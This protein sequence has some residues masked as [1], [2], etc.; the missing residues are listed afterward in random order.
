MKKALPLTLILIGAALLITAVVFW[1]DSSTSVEPE[2]FGKSLRD[3]ITLIAGLGVSIKGWLDL[4]KKEKPS[5]SQVNED[6]GVIVSGRVESVGEDIV[7]RDKIVQNIHL[8]SEKVAAIFTNKTSSDDHQENPY[9][10][11][12][13]FSE[14]DAP[15]FYGREMAVNLLAST[16]LQ[17]PRF[18]AVIGSSGSGKSSL[19]SAGLIPKLLKSDSNWVIA[20]CRPGSNPFNELA[21]VLLSLTRTKKTASSRIDEIGKLA[22]SLKANKVNIHRVLEKSLKSATNGKHLLL[23]IDQFEELYTQCSDTGVRYTFLDKLVAL[24]T[25]PI[26]NTNFS[27]TIV[28]VLRADFLEQVLGYRSLGNVFNS[29]PT[30]MLSPMSSEELEMAIINPARKQKIEFEGGLSTRILYDVGEEPGNLPLLEFALTLLWDRQELGKLTF[31]AYDALG[32]VQGALTHYAEFIYSTLNSDEQELARQI[33]VQLIEPGEKDT[34]RLATKIELG[35]KKWE[36]VQKLATSRMLVTSLDH[37][38]QPIVEIVHEALI[39]NWRRLQTWMNEDREFRVWQEQFRDRLHQWESRRRDSRAL[40]DGLAFDEAE[41]WYAKRGSDF[42][43]IESEFFLLSL[44]Q[45]SLKEKQRRELIEENR[46]LQ[47]KLTSAETLASIGTVMATLQHRISN[48]LNIILPNLV[49]LRS[50]INSNDATINEILDIIER[51]T[52]YTADILQKIQKPFKI[53]ERTDIN[54]NTVITDLVS[55]IKS[56]KTDSVSIKVDLD[57]SI[58][59][60]KMRVDQISEVLRNLI[61]NALRAMDNRGYLNL[62]SNLE[63]NF[64]KI[65]VQDT[66]KGIPLKLRQHLFEFPVTSKSGSGFGLW[67][68]K[69]VLKTINGEIKIEKSDSSGTIMLIE[70]PLEI[71]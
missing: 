53:I 40:L 21:S 48:T 7:G 15:F 66:G 10:G 47:E 68:S 16:V 63:N 20:K 41:R 62:T 28:V 38:G 67:Y 45:Q 59:V 13:A 2:G 33:F 42:S 22:D 26:Q 70:I 36:L 46:E 32:K 65:R 24:A 37:T 35:E 17:Y 55:R 9:R 1:I 51:N 60:M 11:L 29:S 5:S 25:E 44:E 64:V 50:R 52:R 27:L 71:K 18:V 19:I 39:Q 61:D 49:R 14:K 3:W 6:G 4:L 57:K 56:E 8:D 54:I 30:P 69:M 43:Q 23:V 34:R 31:K 12:S 58:P